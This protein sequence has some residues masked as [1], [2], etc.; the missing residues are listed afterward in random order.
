MCIEKK[1]ERKISKYKQWLSLAMNFTSEI[2]F[3]SLCFSVFYKSSVVGIYYFYSYN[4]ILLFILLSGDN[5]TLFAL[6]H[7]TLS[8]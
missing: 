5:D 4:Q 7:E 8:T 1:L 3:S 2:L 6:L